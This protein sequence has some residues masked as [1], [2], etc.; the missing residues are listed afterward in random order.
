MDNLL[1][2]N[3]GSYRSFRDHALEHLASI[4]VRHVE[5]RA[6]NRDDVAELL[7]Q[8]GAHG[9]SA[10]TVMAPCP[11]DREDLAEQ[12]GAAC[13]SAAALGAKVVFVSAKAGDVPLETA[14]A[15][16][17][18][19]GDAAAAHGVKLALETHPDLCD[20]GDKMVA[21]MDAIDHPNVGVNF[22]T[23][24][25]YYYNE[26]IDGLDELNKAID[27][28]VAVHLKDTSGG[29]KTWYFPTLGE[30]IVDFAGAFAA[31]NAKG[32]R[33]PFTMELEGIEGESLNEAETQARVADSVAYLRGAGLVP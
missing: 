28:I 12:L 22:D 11:L 18:A 33:G 21:T 17:R 6:P 20:N 2:C 15:R 1:S 4:G 26:G 19:A 27:K 16:L 23:A 14:Y 10:T 30:G 29:Y 25:I 7:D 3:L 31:L 8:L 13:E 24:N 5:V 9:L 32:F